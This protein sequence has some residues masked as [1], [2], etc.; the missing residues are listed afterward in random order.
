MKMERHRNAKKKFFTTFLFDNKNYNFIIFFFCKIKSESKFNSETCKNFN[1]KRSLIFKF[2][3][4]YSNFKTIGYFIFLVS[5]D[6]IIKKSEREKLLLV[7]ICLIVLKMAMVS[8]K[9]LCFVF[10]FKICLIN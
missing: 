10:L 3:Q 8:A 5:R 7:V 1:F 6:L 4:K 9:T 2:I